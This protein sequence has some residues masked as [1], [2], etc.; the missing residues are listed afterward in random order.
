MIDCCLKGGDVMAQLSNAEKIQIMSLAIQLLGSK[1]D[2]N[3]PERIKTL[4]GYY[5]AMVEKVSDTSQ[6]NR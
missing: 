1:Y 3:T 6:P 4:F 5:D 2:G